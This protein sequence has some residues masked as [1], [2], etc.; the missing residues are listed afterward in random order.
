MSDDIMPY[1][2]LDLVSRSLDWEFGQ[3][4]YYDCLKAYKAN[5]EH[6]DAIFASIEKEREE[7]RLAREEFRKRNPSQL[8]QMMNE[9]F[10]DDF[11][12]LPLIAKKVWTDN[13][14]SELD[15]RCANEEK[16]RK[17]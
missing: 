17:E 1:E 11:N 2:L 10:G 14:Q 12:N 15:T 6:F 4:S 5:K 16:Y 7:K 13:D 9:I 3:P 8:K